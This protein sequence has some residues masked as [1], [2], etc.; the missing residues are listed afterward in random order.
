MAIIYPKDGFKR[1]HDIFSQTYLLR[2]YG[3][4]E[5]IKAVLF[6]SAANITSLDWLSAKNTFRI[7]YGDFHIPSLLDHVSVILCGIACAAVVSNDQ[8]IQEGIVNEGKIKTVTN[9]SEANEKRLQCERS[10]E[11]PT[12]AWKR[13]TIQMSLAQCSIQRLLQS[14]KTPIEARK[15][16]VIQ[17]SRV[18]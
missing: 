3:L 11:T 17:M 13:T 9:N 2:S 15:H 16:T 5:C 4:P 8:S 7:Q 14:E 12:D 18:Q 6:A 10:E 1:N